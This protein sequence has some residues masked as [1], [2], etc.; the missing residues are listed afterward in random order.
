VT[1]KGLIA[2]AV[3]VPLVL[4]VVWVAR[5][6]YWAEVTLPMPPKGEALTNPFYAAQ[7]LVE[8]LGA[9]SV[10]DRQ[11]VPVPSDSVI[12]LSAWNWSLSRTRRHALE[13]WVE[14]GGRLVVDRTV[15]D[16]E[17]DFE[18]WSGI[19]QIENDAVPATTRRT[20]DDR[21]VTLREEH[22]ETAA[23]TG[24]A[25]A[26]YD[27]CNADE[28][29][30]LASDRKVPWALRNSV[31]IQAIRVPIGRGSVT[32]INANPF[33]YRYLLDGDHA[34]LLVAATQLRKADDVHFLSED[35]A[36]WLLAL[37][38]QYGAPVVASLFVIVALVLWRSA[39]RFGPLAAP[40][41]RAR[42]SLAEQIR[43]SGRFALRHGSGE[44]LH[45]ACVRALEEAARRRVKT[46][47]SLDAGDRA[48]ALAQITGFNRNAL[49]AAVQPYS[50]APG[51]NELR[52]TIA[53]LETARRQILGLDRQDKH[54]T[55]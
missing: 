4:L 52:R 41:Q 20:R 2:L 54:G 33:R 13:Q 40:D 8:A 45:T 25:V 35:D 44:S 19:V 29:W 3:A 18:R 55:T 32:M 16:T 10:R 11:M 46:Y 23:A 38:W 27:V 48:G 21:C 17:D 28:D 34:R 12:V 39:V 31:G 22:H 47:S 36:P 14:S 42:R 1:R 37:A 49:A 26:S 5:N 50:R 53:F 24:S 15:I 9:R 43:G 7:R 30:S 6:S 51:V